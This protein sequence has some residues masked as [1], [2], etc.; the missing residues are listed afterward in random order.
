[1]NRQPFRP[2]VLCAVLVIATGLAPS[3]VRAQFTY[4]PAGDIIASR[5]AA[6]E[7]VS[8]PVPQQVDT[9]FVP[10]M[11]F[12]I[13]DGPAY[14]N[15]Q[16]FGWGG[17]HHPP[18]PDRPQC[19]AAN[20]SYPWRDTFCEGAH[21]GSGANPLCGRGSSA[22]AGV[23]IR[24]SSCGVHSAVAALPGVVTI[25]GAITTN[26]NTD[27]GIR[28]V[29]L[30]MENRVGSGRVACGARIGSVSNLSS[31]RASAAC[32]SRHCTTIHLHFEV[33]MAVRG[34]GI[35]PVPGYTSLVH[36]YER[37]LNGDRS[38]SAAPV[39]AATPADAGVWSSD[40]SVRAD[41]YVARDAG[42]PDGSTSCLSVTLGRT[43]DEGTCVQR[44]PD[45]MPGCDWYECVGGAWMARTA[46]E[47]SAVSNSVA[48]PSCAAA[49][50]CRSDG[51]TCDDCTARAGCGFCAD[52]GQCHSESFETSC[53]DWRAVWFECI[54]CDSISECGECATNGCGWCASSGQCMAARS[55]GSPL[56]PC[57]DWHYT[58]TLEWCLAH[59]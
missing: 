22:H 50:P 54:D 11:R 28:F 4:L 14:A 38:C 10:N 59:P 48:N 32:P 17:Y 52:D 39:D 13:A 55:G 45:A 6:G 49:D 16:V 3:V 19:T 26:L 33:R 23:D 24:P 43:V 40:A 21:N 1:M 5:N 20:Y 53:R 42:P 12:P 34:L 37:L 8:A 58:D 41:A 2:N 30:H 25:G 51:T 35:V 29:Y 18:G 57:T 56:R 9:L 7:L 47:C 15:S 27:Q 36:A 44:D 31:G 46:T